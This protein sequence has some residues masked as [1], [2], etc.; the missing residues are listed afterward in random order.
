VINVENKRES[1]VKKQTKGKQETGGNM[2]D[3]L[4]R[5]LLK[6]YEALIEDSLYKIQSLN[7]NNIIIPE[8]IDIT[9][10]VDKLLEIIAGAE[11]KL[12]AM[13]K[14]YGKKEADKTVL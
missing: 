3:M 8:H 2:N 7:E 12:A 10:E 1:I 4:F 14:Y 5:T 6:R 9:G 11:D 13:R